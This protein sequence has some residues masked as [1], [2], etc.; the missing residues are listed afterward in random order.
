MV[1]KYLLGK[2]RAEI[3]E[4]YT[5]RYY[6]FHV[7]RR[8]T[9]DILTEYVCMF[10]SPVVMMAHL[11][12]GLVIQAGYTDVGGYDGWQLFYLTAV[13]FAVELVT[14]CVC[15]WYEN[16]R[17]DLVGGWNDFIDHSIKSR[18]YLTKVLPTF[19]FSLCASGLM[20]V[21]GF[22]TFQAELTSDPCYFVS[23]CI[24]YPCNPDCFSSL[25]FTKVTNGTSFTTSPF[26]QMAC[27]A[28]A[29]NKTQELLEQCS[30]YID[31]K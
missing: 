20:M 9:L 17:L 23:K 19:I 21:Y 1:D 14:D 30:Y 6:K 22:A 10:V 11:K 28:I 7:G 27:E 15:W 16:P 29:N 4:K 13:S 2:S 25:G 18:R 12:N 5:S 26:F 31:T 8:I 24:P 3:H